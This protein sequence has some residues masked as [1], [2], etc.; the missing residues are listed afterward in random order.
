MPEHPHPHASVPWSYLASVFESGAVPLLIP[1]CRKIEQAKPY[2]DKI[3]GL[4]LTGGEDICPTK[5]DQKPSA[6]VRKVSK[7]RDEL[8]FKLARFAIEK[9][10]PLFGI[11]RGMQII[12]V[13]LGGTLH[14][15][16]PDISKH[17]INNW[18]FE[19]HQIKLHKGT[20]LRQYLEDREQIAVNSIHH[21]AVSS[22]GKHLK[23]SASSEDGIIEAIESDNFNFLMGVQCHPEALWQN[24]DPV[25]LNLFETFAKE[26]SKYRASKV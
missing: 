19:A 10:M 3:D 7:S 4:L 8:E 21:Q 1:A 18:S 13:L 22:L 6:F 23:V 2:F 12:N 17:P 11:C 26:S 14:Q 24:S 9:N 25:W 16:I 20:H 5:Y 15:H